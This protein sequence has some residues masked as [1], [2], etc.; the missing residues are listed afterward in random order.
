MTS[1]RLGCATRSLYASAGPKAEGVSTNNRRGRESGPCRLLGGLD[2]ARH[3]V[4]TSLLVRVKRFRNDLYMAVS[5][6]LRKQKLSFVMRIESCR[7][8]IIN[9]VFLQA[10][11][12]PPSCQRFATS[13]TRQAPWWTANLRLS[14]GFI[15]PC[16][17]R[18]K[19]L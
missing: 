4:P 17:S 1:I 11:G 6:F 12:N 5:T 3:I 13:T 14:S 7:R 15:C 9:N 8:K 2:K 19:F 18:G 10:Q 16:R